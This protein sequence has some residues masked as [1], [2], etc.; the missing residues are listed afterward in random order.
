MKEKRYSNEYLRK[1]LGVKR[2]KILS[3]PLRTIQ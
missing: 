1:H 2:S 3:N